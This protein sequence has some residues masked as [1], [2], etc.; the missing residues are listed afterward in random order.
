SVAAMAT[1]ALRYRLSADRDGDRYRLRAD[2]SPRGGE[3]LHRVDFADRDDI[4]VFIPTQFVDRRLNVEHGLVFVS[5]PLDRATEMSG[6]F[7]G[8]LDFVANKKDFDLVVQLYQLMPS[9]E[10]FSLTISP[11]YQQRASYAR[12]RGHRELLVPGQRNSIEFRAE[13]L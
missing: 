11:A 3:I 7:S 4:S 5:D 6:L 12:D 8:R 2:S 13:R 9:G 10:Y 1:G